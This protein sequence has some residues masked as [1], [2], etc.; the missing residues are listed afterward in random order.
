MDTPVNNT[1]PSDNTIPAAQRALRTLADHPEDAAALETLAVSNVLVPVPPDMDDVPEDRPETLTLPVIED[2]A[3]E[4]RVP[5]FTSELRM[6]R[7][8]PGTTG[9]RQVPM[10]LLAAYWPADDLGMVIDVGDPDALTL[11][12]ERVRHLV[13]RP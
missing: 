10:A 1:Y 6:A 3:H 7:T 5:V 12:A 9:Y 4:P 11:T 2:P 13:S 8:L